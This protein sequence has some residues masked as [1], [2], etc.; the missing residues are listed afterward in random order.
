MI[1]LVVIDR[2]MVNSRL[3]ITPQAI[4]YSHQ[5]IVEVLIH[6]VLIRTLALY[7]LEGVEVVVVTILTTVTVLTMK[8]LTIHRI[9]VMEMMTRITMMTMRTTMMETIIVLAPLSLRKAETHAIMLSIDL[10][11]IKECCDT[12]QLCIIGQLRSFLSQT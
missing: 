5:L 1:S 10:V 12:E 9:G 8:I 11:D 6:Q 2:S 4:H 7:D 3:L